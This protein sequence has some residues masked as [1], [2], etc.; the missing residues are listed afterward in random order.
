MVTWRR[1]GVPRVLQN[2]FSSWTTCSVMVFKRLLRA[3]L[4]Q[5]ARS[6]AIPAIGHCIHIVGD[7]KALLGHFEQ[8]WGLWFRFG[9]LRRWADFDDVGTNHAQAF[10]SLWEPYDTVA[11]TT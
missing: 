11:E 4:S 2:R 6:P 8:P 7:A 5:C 10:E 3:Q 9:N 1:A